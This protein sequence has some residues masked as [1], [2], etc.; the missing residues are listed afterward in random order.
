MTQRIESFFQYD[1]K[2]WTLFLNMIQWIEPFFN[3]T[4]RL[5]RFL[6]LF[7]VTQRIEPFFCIW[8]KELN[9]LLKIWLTDLNLFFLHDSKNWTLCKLRLKE[10]NLFW[11][12]LKELNLTFSMT[13]RIELFFEIWLKELNL[14]FQQMAQRIETF[15]WLKESNF[16]QKYDSKNW[17]FFFQHDS[18]ILFNTTRR[19]ELFLFFEYDSKNWTF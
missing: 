14:L 5:E 7:Y 19:I 11:I 18:M 1:S 2:N 3:M 4:Q 9:L 6:F 16:F 12:W 15:L 13:Q 8:L 17:F 10:L